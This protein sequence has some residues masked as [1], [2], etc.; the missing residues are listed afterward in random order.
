MKFTHIA[1]LIIS[2]ALFVGVLVLMYLGY[3]TIDTLRKDI[4]TTN[5]ELYSLKSKADRLVSLR[6]VTN[7]TDDELTRVNEFFVSSNGALEF[8]EYIE[9]LAKKSAL[10]YKIEFFDVEQDPDFLEQGKELLK[11]SIRV[12]GTTKNTRYFLSLIESLPYNI[13]IRRVDLRR[14]ILP[15]ISASSTVGPTKDGWVTLVDFSVVKII[16]K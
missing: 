2:T 4:T 3:H 13:R 16:E 5:D 7:S 1:P 12:T 6:Q 9:N 10:E 8:V 11:T 15:V 14:S